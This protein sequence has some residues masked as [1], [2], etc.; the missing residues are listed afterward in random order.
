MDATM[1]YYG[2]DHGILDISLSSLIRLWFDVLLDFFNNS[3]EQF[4]P[5]ILYKIFSCKVEILIMDDP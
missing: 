3:K 1:A 2:E 4:F 5:I